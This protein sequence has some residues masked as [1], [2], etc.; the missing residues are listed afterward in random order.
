M[1]K[2]VLGTHQLPPTGSV[3]PGWHPYN[4]IHS[5]LC[6][7]CNPQSETKKKKEVFG[8]K[9]FFFYSRFVEL[10]SIPFFSG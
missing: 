8:E 3:L 2:V 10:C 6:T 9:V 1:S 4:T 5:L 7:Y